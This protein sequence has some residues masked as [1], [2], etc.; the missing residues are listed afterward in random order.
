M[1][2]RWQLHAEKQRDETFLVL[3]HDW[4]HSDEDQGSEEVKDWKLEFAPDENGYA[5]ATN[6]LKKRGDQRT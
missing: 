5:Y 1:A 4:R 6:L 2:D 3:T